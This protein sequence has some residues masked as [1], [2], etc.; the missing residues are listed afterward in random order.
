MLGHVSATEM[1][2]SRPLSHQPRFAQGIPSGL[3]TPDEWLA[4]QQQGVS[5]ARL[6]PA[7]PGA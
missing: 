1:L 5:L 4:G 6:G 3:D 2:L 7:L